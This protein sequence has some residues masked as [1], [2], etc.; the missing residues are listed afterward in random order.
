[1][2][3]VTGRTGERLTSAV[4]VPFLDEE[5]YL[6]TFLDSVERQARRPDALVL[7]DDG[8]RDRSPELARDFAAGRQWAT[9]LQ[10]P[11]RE[12]GDDRL[13][14]A[15]ELVA[16]LWA[17]EHVYDGYDVVAKMD[18]DLR[19][20]PDHVAAVMAAFERDQSLGMAGTYLYT[21]DPA[22]RLQRDGHAADHVR[23][24][25]RFYRRR[26]LDD[27][28]PL[29]VTL[30]WDGGDEVRARAR[31]WRT[32]SLDLSG[33]QTVH[34]RPTGSHD[35]ALR[36]YKRWGL[37]AYAVGAHPLAVLAGAAVRVRRRPPILG[38]LAYLWGWM[39]AGLRRAPR[40]PEDIRRAKRREQAQHFRRACVRLGS[41][42]LR[43]REPVATRREQQVGMA[44]EE[45]PGTPHVHAE[46]PP[47]R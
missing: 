24:A 10:R 6:G 8:S 34:L 11:R 1:V 17:L 33:E 25:T 39:D 38:S 14:G 46:R 41:S 9:L 4:I 35:G 40:L 2:I 31:G 27:I 23:G 20:A 5:R 21:E 3:A 28:S 19:L 29:P 47:E 36:A 43:P 18:A 45:A 13:V 12:S 30:G 32:H 7:V 42:V 26:C 15:P 44:G 16:F 22:G 37:C